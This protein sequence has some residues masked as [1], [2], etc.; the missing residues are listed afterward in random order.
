MVNG[1]WASSPLKT[2]YQENSEHLKLFL[3]RAKSKDDAVHTPSTRA[4]PQRSS[5]DEPKQTKAM[6]KE[7]EK[8]EQKYLTPSKQDLD[9]YL[10]PLKQDFDSYLT[11]SKQDSDAYLTPS[12]P[13][14][15][16]HKMQE[17]VE[18]L[19]L[20]LKNKEEF[21]NETM[22]ILRCQLEE[23]RA[24]NSKL[25]L[26]NDYL[27]K[28]VN[29]SKLYRNVRRNRF[30][31]EFNKPHTYGFHKPVFTEDFQRGSRILKDAKNRFRDLKYNDLRNSKL[32]DLTAEFE[33]DKELEK[34]GLLENLRVFEKE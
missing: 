4:T 24:E 11:P 22:E 27:R 6:E 5:D 15:L 3:D 34:Y 10:T 13:N 25:N 14:F 30:K 7:S 29:S 2:S 31:E 1:I 9:T 17:S 18:K 23:A 12:K 32:E 8:F 33:I 19:R 28:K 16:K 26:E 21:D 20:Y